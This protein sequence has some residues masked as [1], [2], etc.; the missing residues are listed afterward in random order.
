MVVIF[1]LYVVQIYWSSLSRQDPIKAQR[2]LEF[3]DIVS[4]L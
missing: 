1:G 4:T 2:G 3:C